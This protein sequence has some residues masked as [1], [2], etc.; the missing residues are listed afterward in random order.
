MRRPALLDVN[1][2]LALFD[3]EHVHHEIAHDWFDDQHKD[4]WATCPLTENGFVRLLS[5]P[6]SG[7][8]GNRPS[9]LIKSLRTFCAGGHHVFWPDSVSLRDPKLFNLA[10][11]QGPRQLTDIYLLGLAKKMDGKLA[12]FDQSIPL[13]AVVG[14]TRATLAVLSADRD[15]S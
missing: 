11:V 13:R 9:E 1:I 12:T 2:L 3:P 8:E 6:G 7:I 10:F 5:H 4:G 15:A 14:A